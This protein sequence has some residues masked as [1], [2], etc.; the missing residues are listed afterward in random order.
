MRKRV[1][2]GKENKVLRVKVLERVIQR[3]VVNKRKTVPM[4]MMDKEVTAAH[5]DKKWV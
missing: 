5:K 4:A 3:V 2:K 1:M